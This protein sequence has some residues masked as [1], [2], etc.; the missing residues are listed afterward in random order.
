VQ[1][2]Q[3]CVQISDTGIGIPHDDIPRLF[4]KFYRV[5]TVEHM[6][7]AGTGLGLSIVNEI[8][9]QHGG[10]LWVDSEVGAGTTFGFAIPLPPNGNGN[11]H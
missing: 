10:H 4:E 3:V 9:Q 5:N 11:G 2:N 6:R 7:V 1:P 8:V